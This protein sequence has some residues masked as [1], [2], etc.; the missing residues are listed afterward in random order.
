MRKLIGIA[1]L[2]MLAG[3]DVAMAQQVHHELGIDLGLAYNH[4][5]SLNGIS[6][7]SDCGTFSMGTPVDVRVGFAS[8]GATS[9]EPRFTFNYVSHAG[10]HI[11]RFDPDANV[12]FG[13]AGSARSG[14]Y[15]TVGAGIDI[16]SAGGGGSSETATQV[17]LNGG[18]GTRS[19]DGWRPEAFFR[20]NFPNSGKGIPSS[21]DIGVRIGYSFWR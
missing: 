14:P 21:Y 10:S 11:L 9:F 4:L 7:S 15:V 16:I 1:L 18:V 19:P 2:A 3:T 5:G 12:L 8:T 20:Y 17:S 6:C 13:L